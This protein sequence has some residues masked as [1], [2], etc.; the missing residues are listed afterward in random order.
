MK[1]SPGREMMLTRKDVGRMMLVCYW[2]FGAYKH[3]V[4]D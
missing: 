1:R 4:L 2:R 3:N